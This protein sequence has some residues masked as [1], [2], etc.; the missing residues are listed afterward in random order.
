MTKQN[1]PRT[2]NLYGG[3]FFLYGGLLLALYNCNGLVASRLSL[4]NLWLQ[5]TRYV[6]VFPAALPHT[7]RLARRLQYQ[8]IRSW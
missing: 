1:A 3:F 5:F 8:F 2:K 6:Y 7:V 4:Y